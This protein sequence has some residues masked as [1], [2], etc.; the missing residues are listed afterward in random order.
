MVNGI[1]NCGMWSLCVSLLSSFCSVL[2][3][4]S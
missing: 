1:W 4:Y 2:N 3:G